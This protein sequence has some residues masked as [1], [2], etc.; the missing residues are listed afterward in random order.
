MLDDLAEAGFGAPRSQSELAARGGLPP[1]L[2]VERLHRSH[3]VALVRKDPASYA[4]RFDPVP[5]DEPAR[6]YWPVTGP[7]G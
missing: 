5:E 6:Y 1:W 2:G 3:R 4:T 7:A